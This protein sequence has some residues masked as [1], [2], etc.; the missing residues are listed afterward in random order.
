MKK[1]LYTILLLLLTLNLFAQQEIQLS[2]QDSALIIKYLN[3]FEEQEKLG[4]LKEASDNLNSAAMIYWENN[5]FADA[6]KYYEESLKRNEKLENQNAIAMINSNIALINADMG[7][8][9]KALIYF[10]KT[11]ASRTANKETVGIIA[12]LTNISV[13]YN[14]LKQY[15]KSI[16]STTKALEYALELNDPEQ[17]RSCYGTLA[18]TYEKKGDSQKSLYYFEFY[19]TFH[20]MIQNTKVAKVGTELENEK[21][22]LLLTEEE[23]KKKELELTLSGILLKNKQKEL[24]SKDSTN[25][26]L[27]KDLTRE[28]L[29][30]QYLNKEKE[31]KDTKIKNEIDKKRKTIIISIIITISLIF[32]LLIAIYAY[33]LKKK[34]NTKLIYQNQQILQQR[35]EIMQQN[36]ELEYSKNIIEK[37]NEKIT[38]SINYAKF[39]QT[40]TLSKITILD[41]FV[42]EAIIYYE[43]RD[44]VSG[45]FY[46]FDKVENKII[47]AAVDCTGHGVP[48]GFLSMIGNELLNKIV[49]FDKITKPSEILTLLDEGIYKTLNQENTNNTD[50]MDIALF[51]IDYTENSICFAGANNPLILIQNDELNIVKGSKNSIGGRRHK[52]KIFDDNYFEIKDNTYLYVFSDGYLDQLGGEK[53]RSMGTK[54]FANFI[55]ENHKT[56]MDEQTELLKNNFVTWQRREKQIDDVLIIGVKL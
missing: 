6:T 53:G 7:N 45:D 31:L 10:Q 44:I 5:H 20:E 42:K 2:R 12:A 3:A 33:S 30:N 55:F 26:S 18:E 32:I 40:S 48:G 52:V 43:P 49:L 51:T 16:E 56:K 15:D 23:N 28:Q 25:K 39:I 34:D 4:N 37:I 8:Y 13:V 11:L 47:V 29:E 9:E 41:N 24:S 50:G 27:L 19:K 35:E 46:W 54:N 22:K 21:L 1:F 36:S 17:I 38:S 14:N